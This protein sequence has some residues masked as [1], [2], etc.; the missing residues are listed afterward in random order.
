MLSTSES[1]DAGVSL[2]YTP[3]DSVADPALLD[4]YRDLLDPA[5]RQRERSFYF[6][7]DRERHVI[8][9]ALLRTVLTRETGSAVAPE[10]WEFAADRFGKPRVCAPDAPVPSFNLTHADGL[11][12]V[13]VTRGAAI[14]VDAERI[15]GNASAVADSAGLFAAHETAAIEAC[16]PDERAARFLEYWTLKE[17]RVKAVGG[18][19][20]LPFDRPAFRFPGGPSIELCAEEEAGAHGP[21]WKFWQLRLRGDFVVAI[22]VERTG[23]EPLRLQLR[24]TVPLVSETP[25]PCPPLRESA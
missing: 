15:G 8:A 9:H 24:E 11:A 20:A 7:R 22:C 1:P 5:E 10:C 3:F 25:V 18:G 12:A 23:V 17:A 14:G 21:G 19:L 13:A 4:R 16:P 2:W 6:E